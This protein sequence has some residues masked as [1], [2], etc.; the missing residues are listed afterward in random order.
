[1]P[2]RTQ[3]FSLIPW[4]G[5]LNSSVD[6]GV[7][8]PSD[9]VKADNVLFSSTG[10]RLKREG[11]SY[12]DSAS[13]VPAVTHRASSGTTR[14]L[15]FASALDG[16]AKKL[17]V[18]EAITITTSG[19]A[20]NETTYYVST[21]ATVASVSG[22]TITYTGVGSLTE[23]TTATSTLTVSRTYG[24]TKV[25]DYWRFT[26]SA[27]SQELIAITAQPLIFKYDTSGNR[28]EIAKD[29]TGTARVG[30]AIHSSCVVFNNKLIIGQTR[31]GNTPIAYKPE[32]DADWRNLSSTA[33]DF[34]IATV[35]LNRIWTN[36]KTNPDR[37]HY[38]A[39]GDETK[40][41]GTD[42]SGALD[43]RPGDGDP[44]GITAIFAFK[45]RLFVA[46]KTK[47]YQVVG[48]SPENFQV[49]DVSSGLGIESHEATA[50]IDQDDV[51]YL[52]SKGIHSVSTTANYG[53][54]SAS[55]LS[56][57][58]QPTFNEFVKSRL[59]DAS[60]VHIA[61]LNST[62]ITISEL[63]TNAADN[64]W[65]YNIQ[66]K[67]WYRWP[68]IDC[69]AL[70]SIL[71]NGEPTLFIG[72]SDCRLIKTQNGTYTDFSSSGIRFRIK[73]GT[74]YPDSNPYTMKAFK[75]LTMFYRPVGTYTFTVRVKIDNHSEQALVF[76]ASG[77]GDELGVDF[78][79]GQSILGY[80]ANFSPFTLPIDGYGRGITI[81]VEQTGTNEQVAIYGFALEYELAEKAQETIIDPGAG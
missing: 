54:F 15:T 43:I 45:G 25:F 68:D 2:T 24:I 49:L 19:G 62:F 33:P 9:L 40:W 70:G 48:D 46:K 34:S 67:E 31:T 8:P 12:Y 74:I 76:S 60:M 20:G 17:V 69:Q 22:T 78:I 29:G 61:P 58:I 27:Y 4:T 56:A 21:T 14:T 80:S 64:L 23:G 26:G 65:V 28:T 73:S 47:L 77:E 7:L 50:Y 79:L 55:F 57:K 63:D 51:L 52:S 18:G 75:R 1:M 72:T 30:T 16:S 81:E 42:D 3:V 5:G 35:Y 6:S 44:V 39:T 41:Q 13:D 37:L 53:D 71:V 38:C 10:A 59:D 11:F 36:D 32:I 66:S